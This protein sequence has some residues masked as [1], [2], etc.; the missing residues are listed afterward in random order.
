MFKKFKESELFRGSLV[1]LILINI[2]NIIN[3]LYQIIMARMLGPSDYGILAVLISLTYIFAIPALS[4]QTAVVKKI[5]RLNV[6]KDYDKMKG[7]LFHFLRKLFIFSLILF[8][9]FAI[10]SLLLVKPLN[11]PFWLLVLT[12]TLIITSFIYPIAAGA[13]Q[14]LKKFSALGWNTILVFAVKLVLAIILVIAGF[15][16]YGAVWGFIFGMVVGFIV[17]IPSLKKIINAKEKGDGT[18]ILTK[19]NGLIFMAILVLVFIYS[20]DVILVKLF[21]SGEIVGQY[22]VISMIGKIVLFST[23]SIGNVMFPISSERHHAKIKTKSIIKKAYLSVL[24]LCSIAVLVFALFP[25][26]IIKLLFGSQYVIISSSL[27]YIGVA[28]SFIA[29]L[30][31]LLLYRISIDELKVWHLGFLSF[32]FAV[33]ILLLSFYHATIEQFSMVFMFSTIITFI[34]AFIFIRKWRK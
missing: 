11:I 2:G 22:A 27:V 18:K 25:E 32:L 12:G 29:F 24:V 13:L 8:V 28:F 9:L 15:K 4:I 21:F 1:L 7:L 33:Q 30:N 3:Y 6:K 16:V 23:M 14:G 34:G 10:L 19:E 26:L 31:I 17:A 5:A 20:I